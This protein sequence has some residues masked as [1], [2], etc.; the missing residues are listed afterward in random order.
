YC[1]CVNPGIQ[2]LPFHLLFFSDRPGIIEETF[3]TYHRHWNGIDMY[4]NLYEFEN[5]Q[6]VDART[7][8]D[9]AVI[10][11]EDDAPD[12]MEHHMAKVP[13]A[14]WLV[15]LVQAIEGVG[16][17]CVSGINPSEVL[18]FAANNG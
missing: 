16:F 14:P 4:S 17:R 9:I 3:V 11:V 15:A 2:I 18:F 5:Y 12:Q 7:K 13:G 1:G 6:R 8:N 10:Y